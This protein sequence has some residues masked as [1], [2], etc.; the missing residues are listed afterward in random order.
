MILQDDMQENTL[1]EFSP[2][3]YVNAMMDAVPNC[4]NFISFGRCWD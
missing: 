2:D 3:T 4:W 1:L